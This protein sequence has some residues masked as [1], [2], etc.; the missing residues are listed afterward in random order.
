[1]LNA[2][3][4]ATIAQLALPA[5]SFLVTGGASLDYGAGAA[6]YECQLVDSAGFID[7]TFASN[8]AANMPGDVIIQHAVTLAG[9]DTVKFQ[10]LSSATPSV[11]GGGRLDAIQVGTVH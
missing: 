3:T 10:C 5:G 2:I 4:Y 11:A 8:P 6:L 9:P 7:S 1:M